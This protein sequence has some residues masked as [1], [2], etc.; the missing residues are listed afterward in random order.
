MSGNWSNYDFDVSSYAGG[1]IYLRFA[2]LYAENSYPGFYVDDVKI[3]QYDVPAQNTT[4]TLTAEE[5]PSSG[6]S[7]PWV[8]SRTASGFVQDND[9]YSTAQGQSAEYT[10]YYTLNDQPI[11]VNGQYQLNLQELTQETS[12][13]DFVR[14]LAVDH[15]AGQKLL[16]MK[17]AT[18]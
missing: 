15:S 5:S 17:T 6:A 12:Y 18:S 14:L 7:C 3:T 16:Q 10:D 9:I 13:T 4:L 1:Q 11:Q 8:F 2:M